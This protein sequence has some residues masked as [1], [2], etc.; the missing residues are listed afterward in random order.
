VGDD[1]A[2]VGEAIRKILE[3]EFDV[4]AV[5]V[6]GNALVSEA[7]RLKPDA[8][9]VDISMPLVNGLEAARRIKRELPETKILFLTMHPDLSY[10]RDAMNLGASGY[11]LKR[12]AGS[13]L[14]T[15]LRTVL[16][17]KTYVAPELLAAIKDPKLRKAVERGRVPVLTERQREILR[18]IAAG[19]SNTEMAA[20]L[21]IA[22]N[23]VRFHRSTIA[24]KLGIF[25]TAELTRYAI[26]HGVLQG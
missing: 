24:R 9:L 15:A 10:I 16:R 18:L 14:V 17:G 6:D 23:T 13:E 12:S 1:H 26:E 3:P 2:L 8:V 4:V 22:A 19:K 20:A 7:I 5:A 25:T 21:S 11:I